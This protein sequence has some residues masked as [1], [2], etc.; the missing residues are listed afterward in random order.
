[1]SKLLGKEDFGIIQEV[2]R[3]SEELL[4]RLAKLPV[5]IV[6]DALGRT[7]VMDA[8][9]KPLDPGMRLCGP[10][11]TVSTVVGDNL[12]IHA[13]LK[14]AQAGDV[15]VIDVRGNT[16]YGLWGNITTQAA[17]KKGLGGLVIDGAVR[18]A[19]EI[20]ACGFPV[21]TR[22]VN[23]RGGTKH[24]PGTV[25][26][27]I[28]CGGIAVAP[29]D[30]IMGEEDGLVVVPLSRCGDIVEKAKER[31]EAEGKRLAAIDAGNL[32]PSWLTP[33]L[34]NAGIMREEEDL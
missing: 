2:E 34:R 23:P 26:M 18:D 15:I 10:A 32:Y 5:P 28:S 31:L 24:G 14:F 12:M 19:G 11:L 30:V 27:P 3:P 17:K 20:R 25:N 16:D 1:M 9:L 29:G 6:G 4:R 7:N 8:G 13:A 22:G 33:A 21:F